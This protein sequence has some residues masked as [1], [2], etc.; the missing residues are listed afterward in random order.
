MSR[1]YLQIVSAVLGMIPV[2]TGIIGM[3]G[4]RDPFYASAILQPM[5]CA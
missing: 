5:P 4:V 3:T 2:V 1:R